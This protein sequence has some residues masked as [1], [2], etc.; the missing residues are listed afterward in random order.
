MKDNPNIFFSYARSG[1][2]TTAKVRPLLDPSSGSLNN[3]PS[4]TSK[5][6]SDQYSSVF[7]Q[8]RPEWDIPDLQQFLSVDRSASTGHILTHFDFTPDPIE[9][10]CAELSTTSA[11]GPD[12]IPA[13]LLKECRQPLK[14]PLW[15][16]WNESLEQGVIPPDLLVVLICPV[17]KGGRRADPDQYRPVALKSHIVKVFERVVRR[18]LVTHLEMCDMLPDNQHG[19]REHRS[20][21]TQLL[22][23][24]DEVLDL[25]E[26]LM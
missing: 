4:F 14:Q 23:H 25:L 12:G 13:S 2:K 24:W 8:P 16:L 21:L 3:D 11:P 1:Q 7:T 17:Y 26:K 6:L 5:V 22:S 18:A 20:T 19:F 10:S 15:Y 9:F